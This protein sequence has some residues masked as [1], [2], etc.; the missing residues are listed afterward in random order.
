MPPS[1]HSPGAS[2]YSREELEEALATYN[3]A[4]DKASETGDWS[5]WADVFTDDADY[6]EHAYGLFK[7]KAAITDWITKV[8]A[9]FPHMTFPQDW[10]AFDEETGCVVFQCQNRLE[11][12]T[13]PGGEPFQFPSWTRLT[14]AGNGKWSC[15]ED[16]YNPA[17]DANRVIGAWLAAGGKFK[18]DPLVE[19]QHP[20]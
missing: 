14:Y 6:I 9:P 18:T 13:D 5:I 16:I 10:I 15:E 11:H 19:M 7:G 2:R 4:R 8:M 3:I 17:R 12:P 1:S 20:S